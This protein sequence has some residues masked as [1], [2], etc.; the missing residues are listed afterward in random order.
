[1]TMDRRRALR[2]LQVAIN[3]VIFVLS[4]CVCLPLGYV[5]KYFDSSC[6][7]DADIYVEVNDDVATLNVENTKWG[8]KDQCMYVTFLPVLVA[9]HAIVW[10]WFFLCLRIALKDGGYV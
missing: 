7:L 2:L 8:D 1:M 9:M 4:L 10:T 5:W 6:L 3:V